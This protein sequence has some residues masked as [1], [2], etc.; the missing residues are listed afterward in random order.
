M[1]PDHIYDAL[2]QSPVGKLINRLVTEEHARGGDTTTPG[3][4]GSII[5]Q[6]YEVITTAQK[7]HRVD[8]RKKSRQAKLRNYQSIAEAQKGDA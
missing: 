5:D 6:L 1:V 7:K 3:G 8:S 2:F 4:H